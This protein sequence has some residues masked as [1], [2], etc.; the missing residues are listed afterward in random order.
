MRNTGSSVGYINF[1][2][3]R[4]G[5]GRGKLMRNSLSLRARR[6]SICRN[7][8]NNHR[9]DFSGK[10]EYNIFLIF[11]TF[12]KEMKCQQVCY[13]LIERVNKKNDCV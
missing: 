5:G 8:L 12:I 7:W 13:W 6:L 11:I 10:G 2:S 4:I 9:N 1:T 3:T